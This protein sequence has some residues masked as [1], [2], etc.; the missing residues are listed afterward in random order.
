[1]SINK[2]GK[3][4]TILHRK[5]HQIFR[6]SIFPNIYIRTFLYFPIILWICLNELLYLPIFWQQNM[7]TLTLAYSQKALLQ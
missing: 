2:E 1:M 6:L 7:D 3:Q 5:V 4:K